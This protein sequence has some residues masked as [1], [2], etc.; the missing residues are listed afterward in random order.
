MHSSGGSGGRRLPQAAAAADGGSGDRR[1]TLRPAADA[2]W[3][4]EMNYRRS[5]AHDSYTL[6]FL[7]D[8]ETGP[9][10]LPQW[11]PTLL[12]LLLQPCTI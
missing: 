1:G 6:M 7:L 9:Q 11:L 2:T 5:R 8:P 3:R 10:L 4:P 12:L